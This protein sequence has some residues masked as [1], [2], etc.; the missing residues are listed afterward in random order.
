MT[1]RLYM[2]MSLDGYIAGRTTGP[3]RSSA[4]LEPIPADRAA[5]SVCRCER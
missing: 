3:G 5:S 4:L 2:S 1:I